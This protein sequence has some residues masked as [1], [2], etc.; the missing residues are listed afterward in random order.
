MDLNFFENDIFYQICNINLS[1]IVYEEFLKILG[2][3][4]KT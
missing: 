4:S 2:I 3:F 1:K